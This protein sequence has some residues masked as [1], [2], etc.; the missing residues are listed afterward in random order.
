M[1]SSVRLASPDHFLCVSKPGVGICH[2]SFGPEG[3]QQ[4][5]YQ[6][7]RATRQ[8]VATES[9]RSSR[10][11]TVRLTKQLHHRWVNSAT[12]VLVAS[13][14]STRSI[15][16][17]SGLCH[18]ALHLFARHPESHAAFVGPLSCAI[19]FSGSGL[20]SKQLGP[21]VTEVSPRRKPTRQCSLVR[22]CDSSP[23]RKYGL[24]RRRARTRKRQ[25]SA[26]PRRICPNKRH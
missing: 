15:W 14:R 23:S 10:R 13:A 12:P 7:L 2:I 20:R 17:G 24:Q 18:V 19:C 26:Q 6:R 21:T 16:D 22:H 3:P 8:I 1:S 5:K 11:M 9:T 25:W 4:A